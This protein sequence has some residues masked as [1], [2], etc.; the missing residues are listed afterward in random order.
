M[1]DENKVVGSSEPVNIERT[2]KIL[3]QLM[4]CI[5]KIKMKGGFGTGFFC[6]IPDKNEILK[7]LMTN[8]HVLNE[9]SLEEN[10]KLNL[11][12]NDENQIVKLDL[13]IERKTY[14]NEDYDLTLI[15]LKEEDKIKNY[16][17]L[18]DNLFQE[19]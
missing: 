9:K 4:N 19:N 2:I 3:D 16:L 18:D 1:E 11:R 13:E 12:L 6:K 10:E 17:E 7:V 15:E 8:Y 14:F 5:C